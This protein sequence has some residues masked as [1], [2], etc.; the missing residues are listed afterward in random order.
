MLLV[1]VDS[2]DEWYVPPLEAA[3]YVLRI[4]EPE[5]HQ[6]RLL[7]GP[8]HPIKLH[9]FSRGSSEVTRML[10]FRDYLRANPEAR[11]RYAQTKRELAARTW[12]HVQHYADAKTEVIEAILAEAGWS[13]ILPACAAAT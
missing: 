6:H 11:N 8:D 9:V 10:R 12:K 2:S 1:V 3:G 13:V 5:W 4:R 7:H